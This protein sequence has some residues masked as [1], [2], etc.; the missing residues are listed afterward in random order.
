VDDARI[1]FR[2]L[3]RGGGYWCGARQVADRWIYLRGLGVD[4][5]TVSV[6][7]LVVE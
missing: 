6:A 2:I 7:E 5:S 1:K 3:D 4:A